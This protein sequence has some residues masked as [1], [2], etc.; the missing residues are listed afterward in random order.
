[1]FPLLYHAHNSRNPE[2]LPF[3]LS[4]AKSA[5]DPVLE[6]GCGTG[7][8]LL[9][10][11]RAGRWVCGVDNDPEMLKFLKEH[12]PAQLNP[13]IHIFQADISSF[14]LGIQ[15]S[16]IILPC[17][18]Y[19]ILSAEARLATLKCVHQH[20]QPDGAFALSIPNPI[21]LKRLP[22]YAEPE[23]EEII[24][25]PVDEEPVEVSSSWARHK[26]QF[27]VTWIYDHL[28][29]N[30]EVERLTYKVNQFIIP[31]EDIDQEFHSAGMQITERFGDFDRSAFTHNSPNLILV[32]Q[33]AK[34]RD[35]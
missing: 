7:R 28:L 31:V 20:L 1:L 13:L 22:R 25:H 6:L 18:T 26:R 35:F 2:D 3:W 33:K 17:N 21:L 5:G 32:A 29:A 11:A 23:I 27:V 30:G 19:S 16:L 12:T 10:L 4:L 9:P 24:P 34:D 14:S 15:F 8:V